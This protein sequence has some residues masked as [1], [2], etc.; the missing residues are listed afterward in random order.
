MERNSGETGGSLW[1]GCLK[2]GSTKPSSLVR[3]SGIASHL[4]SIKTLN[5]VNT[6][7]IKF[8]VHVNIDTPGSPKYIGRL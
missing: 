4:S 6:F 1:R 3:E 7:E 2:R 5:V 8:K